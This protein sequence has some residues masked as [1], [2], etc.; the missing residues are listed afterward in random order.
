MQD[1]GLK[2]SAV[3]VSHCQPVDS[4]PSQGSNTHSPYSLKGSD[5]KMRRKGLVRSATFTAGSTDRMDCL[6]IDADIIGRL[7]SRG[8]I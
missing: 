4:I 6:P 3:R 2:V 7:A 5:G 8:E 1:A